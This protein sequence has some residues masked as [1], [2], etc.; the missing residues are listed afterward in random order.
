MIQAEE[1]RENTWGLLFKLAARRVVSLR[2]INLEL[3]VSNY[4]LR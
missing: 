1:V 2:V 3:P 4:Y